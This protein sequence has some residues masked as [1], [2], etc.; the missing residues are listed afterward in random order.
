MLRAHSPLYEAAAAGTQDDVVIHA[1]TEREREYYDLESF[2]GA[3][4]QVQHSCHVDKCVLD[5]G[6]CVWCSW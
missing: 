4:E 5:L 2:Y 3:A 1:F 6:C